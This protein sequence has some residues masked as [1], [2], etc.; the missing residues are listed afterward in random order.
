MFLE[1]SRYLKV[2]TVVTTTREGL[3][4]T[5]LK[6][7][8]L[9]VLTGPTHTVKDGDQLDI[10]A[11]EHFADGTKFWHIAD[12]NSETEAARLLAVTGAVI[13]VPNA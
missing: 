5:A 7:R 13:V 2:P 4:V 3:T 9:P 6:L 8:A 12:A 11:H 1:N 10:L